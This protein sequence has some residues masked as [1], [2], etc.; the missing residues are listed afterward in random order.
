MRH[1]VQNKLAA[2]KS[3]FNQARDRNVNSTAY[4][5]GICRTRNNHMN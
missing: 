5:T 4:A 3:V 1:Y 2:R